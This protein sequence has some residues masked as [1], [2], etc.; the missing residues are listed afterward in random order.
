MK[1]VTL[2]V[3][4]FLAIAFTMQSQAEATPTKDLPVAVNQVFIPGGFD[5][6]MDAYVVVSG[7]FPN[8]CYKW[9]GATQVDVTNTEHEITSEATVSQGMCIMVLVP[10][11]KEVRL[12]KLDV[13]THKL[14]FVSGDGTYLEKSMTIEE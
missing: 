10:F 12:G 4:S 6:K 14:R 1:S 8:G 7:I 11:S 5:S 3:V 2:T 9:K 13:G